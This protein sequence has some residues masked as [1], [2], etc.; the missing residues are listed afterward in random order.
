MF[1]KIYNSIK[2]IEGVELYAKE[3]D[4]LLS[5]M[6]KKLNFSFP[7]EMELFYKQ[8]NGFN[9]TET[10]VNIFPLDKVILLNESNYENVNYTE[11]EKKDLIVIG[12]YYFE[13][14]LFLLSKSKKKIYSYDF[15]DTKESFVSE[16]FFEFLKILQKNNFLWG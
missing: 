12:D 9:S 8:I 6:N 10:M 14:G 2:L 11:N 5:E 16:S 1:Q 7:L 4:S 15:V 13:G 3:S